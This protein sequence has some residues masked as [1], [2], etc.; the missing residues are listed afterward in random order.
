MK[1]LKLIFI[2]CLVLFVLCE[3]MLRIA[4]QS[5]Y[6]PSYEK[7]HFHEPNQSIIFKN[8]SKIY[9]E[10]DEVKFRT[11]NYGSIIGTT[12]I[13]D[14]LKDNY[15][16]ALGGSTTECAL[17]PEGKRWPD[18]LSMPTINFGKSRLNSAHTLQNLN[19]VLENYKLNPKYLFIMDGIN[20][21]SS[22]LSNGSADLLNPAPKSF[23]RLVL[24]YS[25]SLALIW[26]NIKSMDYLTFYRAQVSVNAQVPLIKDEILREFWKKEKSSILNFQVEV[27]SKLK[28]MTNKK[29]S[30]LVIL[31]QPHA[32]EENYIP[33]T[34]ELRS[35]P[36]I[37]N[38]RLSIK[39]SKWLMDL[40]N[41]T[42]I[43]ASNLVGLDVIDIS[44]C[45]LRVN[46]SSLIYDAYHYTEK[47]SIYFAKCLS[48]SL[49]LTE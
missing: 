39:Q 20:N 6:V 40:Y 41:E 37:N 47:G 33:Q 16:I 34:I 2:N 42:T 8:V 3:L 44:Q 18:L 1:V 5:P 43:E 19:Y 38:K 35:T 31:T 22:Y 10:A 21:L 29:G 11:D 30:R 7:A 15:A 12:R 23:Y 24:T 13:E 36:I 45:F 4:W 28:E 14:I 27:F 49:T 9:G 46:T 26:T 32:F 48:E 25:Y 17:V